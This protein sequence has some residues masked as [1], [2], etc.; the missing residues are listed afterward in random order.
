MNN[1]VWFNTLG[2]GWSIRHIKELQVRI[3]K[4]IQG[5]G[6]YYKKVWINNFWPLSIYER[7]NFLL[8]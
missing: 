3:S 6:G 1:S 4:K 2:L 8:S 7:D 5:Y